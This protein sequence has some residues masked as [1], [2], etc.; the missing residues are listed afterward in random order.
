MDPQAGEQQQLSSH[1]Y[2]EGG[3]SE[4]T[5]Y[6]FVGN[7]TDIV[8][9]QVRFMLRLPALSVPAGYCGCEGE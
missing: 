5:V 2:D 4:T 9:N 3:G 6:D 1:V 7:Q 8:K